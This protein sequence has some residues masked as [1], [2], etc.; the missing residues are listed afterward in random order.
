VSEG[1]DAAR[2]SEAVLVPRPRPRTDIELMAGR[3]VMI[4][5]PPRWIGNLNVV[6]DG[7]ELR[8]HVWGGGIE[9][10]LADW[11]TARS[12]AVYAGA[13][14]SGDARFGGFVCRYE[15]AGMD[16]EVQ[17]NLNLGLLVVATFVSFHP[18]SPLANQFTREFFRREGDAD[19]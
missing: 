2:Q 10:S 3:W 16:V 6:V 8:V 17:A 15:L 13:M 9:P 18:P 4:G 14:T 1:V 11:G 5:E 19:R 12:S 7:D